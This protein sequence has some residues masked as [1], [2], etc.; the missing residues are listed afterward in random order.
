LRMA[1]DIH[2]ATPGWYYF[3]SIEMWHPVFRVFHQYLQVQS[4]MISHLYQDRTSPHLILATRHSGQFH[5]GYYIEWCVE[6]F[7][8]LMSNCC[9]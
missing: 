9:S 8:V 5:P 1:A 3:F 6:F 4:S 7:S 2:N